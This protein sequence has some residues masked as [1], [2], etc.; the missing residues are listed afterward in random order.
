MFIRQ[1]YQ[2]TL[3]L[4]S[5]IPIKIGKGGCW[6]WVRKGQ[7]GE[8]RSG[9][10]ITDSRNSRLMLKDG[11]MKGREREGGSGQTISPSLLCSL[12]ILIKPS[13][14]TGSV[15]VNPI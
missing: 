12:Y 2:G 4:H 3:L 8:W 14:L 5:P 7:G 10:E 15:S 11:G 9:V 6:R 13:A 1:F